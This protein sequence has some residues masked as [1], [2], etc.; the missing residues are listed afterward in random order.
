MFFSLIG[1]MGSM[2]TTQI[3]NTSKFTDLPG[4]F[5]GLHMVCLMYAAFKIIDATADVRFDLAKE[6]ALANQM[7]RDERDSS[8]CRRIQRSSN[9]VRDTIN[10]VIPL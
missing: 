3:R 7:K 6:Y 5:S 9:M 8:V 1:R 10:T 4:K 2:S